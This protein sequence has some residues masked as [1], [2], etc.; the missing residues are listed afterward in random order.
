MASLLG[1]IGVLYAEELMEEVSLL[2]HSRCSEAWKTSA[3]RRRFRSEQT[4]HLENGLT[5]ENGYS[6]IVE[7]MQAKS[8]VHL[9][10]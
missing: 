10:W 3:G 2:Y 8:Q 6:V 9:I 7:L 5:G 1:A 4:E